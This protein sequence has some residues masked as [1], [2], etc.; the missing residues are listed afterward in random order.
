[1]EDSQENNQE[2]IVN[3]GK[4][5]SKEKE[6]P[7]KSIESLLMGDDDEEEEIEDQDNPQLQ[8]LDSLLRSGSDAINYTFTNESI[9]Y[10]N[11]DILLAKH[12]YVAKDFMFM[13]ILLMSSALNFSW[14]YFPFLF[15][16]FLCYFLI[17]KNSICA[18]KSKLFIEYIT[19]IYA[20]FLLSVKVYFIITIKKAKGDIYEDY[21]E[22]IID[23][24]IP[25]LY[26]HL[27]NYL[28]MISILGECLII[29]FSIVSIIISYLC[30]DF[31]TSD[32]ISNSLSKEKFL[33]LMT[34]CIYSAYFT[35]FG[36]AIFNRS[37]STLLYIFIMNLFLYFVSMNSNRRFIFY[38]FKFFSLIMIILLSIQILLINVFNINSIRNSYIDEDAEERPYPRIVNFWT[39]L[40]INQAF[41]FDMD[42]SK[43]TKEF[44][45]YFFAV[46]SLLIYVYSFK[47][48]TKE[49]MINAY[50]NKSEDDLDEEE[51]ELKNCFVKCIEKVIDYFLSPGFI[52]HLC[53][54]SAILWLY[55][56]QNFYSIG[57]I[58]WIFFSFL[59][60]HITLNR[61]VTIIFLSPMVIACLF[62]YHLSN[63]DG[64]FQ[65]IKEEDK[66][67]YKRFG[68]AKF[69]HKVIEY[70]L[71]NI[72]YFLV[73]SFTYTIF[74]RIEKKKL[75]EKHKIEK[76]K[77]LKL[78]V[79]KEIDISNNE[80]NIINNNEQSNLNLISDENENN[81]M[82]ENINDEKI[83]ELYKNLTLFNIILKAIFSNIDKFTL[84]AMYFLAVHSINILHFILVII[85]MF[86]LLLPKVLVKY[87]IA[88][89]IFCQIIFLAEYIIHLFK[90]NIGES[91]IELI[92]IFIPFEKDSQET[93]IEYL[94]Y[95]VAY[96]YYTQYQLNNYAFYQKL[97]SDKDLTLSN[98]VDVKLNEYPIFQKILF[99]IGK[100]ILELY[101]W[102]LISIF[103]V[104]DSTLEISFLFAIKLLIFL[105][106]V[107]RF[108]LVI[109]SDKEYPMNL[110]LNWIFLIFCSLNTIAVYTFQFLC[111]FSFFNEIIDKSDNFFIQNFPAFGLYRY[112]EE[113]LYIK[114]LP[115]F[116]SNLISVLF[117]VEM[118]RLIEED[119]EKE[120]EKKIK[121]SIEL[122]II[123]DAEGKL[124]MKK[125]T[126]ETKNKLLKKKKTI[127]ETKKNILMK[128]KTLDE[129][130]HK[131][132][133]KKKSL[134]LGDKGDDLNEKEKEKEKEDK[135]KI[136]STDSE[137]KSEEKENKL[138]IVKDSEEE[139]E[140]EKMTPAQEYEDNKSKMLILE[141][142]Y[143]FYNIILICTKFYW[144][145]LFLSICIIFTTYDLSIILIVYILIFGITFIRMFHHIINRLTKFISKESFFISRLIRFNLIE[146]VRHVSENIKYRA[147]A[148]KWLLVFSFLSYYLFYLNAIFYL[149]QK[150][151]QK[152][153]CDQ[154]HSPIFDDKDTENKIISIT[155]ILGFDVNLK[156]ENVL[157]AGWV[158]LFF[159]GLIC[160]DVYVQK[161]EN[162][163]NNISKGNRKKYRQ[164]ANRNIQLK[165][166]TFGEDNILMN[167]GANIEKAKTENEEQN[168]NDEIKKSDSKN[169]SK[170]LILKK[171]QTIKMNI[172]AKDAVED[173]AIGRKLIEDFLLIFDRA[174]QN[175]VKLSKTNS[176]YRII[177]IIKKI[178]EEIIIFL[179]ICTAI[180]KLNIWSFIYMIF[181]IYLILT[182]KSMMKYYV[183]YCFIIATIILQSI[184]FVSNLHLNT[185]PNPDEE[186]L[187]IMNEYFHIP[188]YKDNQYNN[189][190]FTNYEPVLNM[191]DEY[192]F[193]YGFGVSHSQ[194]NLI[195][196][197]FI[198]VVILYIYLDYFSYSIYQEANTIGKTSNK[199]FKINYYNLYLNP[200]VREIGLKM[201]KKEYEKHENCMKYNFDLQILNF[202][203][204]KY[205]M[206]NG[207]IKKKDE[208]NDKNKDNNL[209]K[210]EEEKKKEIEEKKIEKLPIHLEDDDEDKEDKNDENELDIN[211]AG[212][213]KTQIGRPIFKTPEPSPLQKALSKAKTLAQSQSNI[214]S[215][216]KD[217][218][219]SGN[220]CFNI[221]RQFIYLSIHNVI[222]IVII[223]ISMMISGL[224]SILYITFSLYFLITSTRIYLGNKYFYP[225]AIKV[226]LRVIIL[227]DI[228]L[229]ILYQSPYID[230]KNSEDKKNIDNNDHPNGY[231]ILEIIGLNKILFFDS[232]Y[233]AI[234]DRDQMILVLAKAIIYLCM[235]LQV[236]VYSSQSFQ[237]YYL[238][239]IITKNYKL[240]RISLMNVFRFNNKRV[241]VM[242]RSIK[243][244]EEMTKQ[245]DELE[246]TLE[247]WN[248]NIIK[249][250]NA[251]LAL[252]K[253]DTLKSVPT[254]EENKEEQNINNDNN[255]NNDDNKEEDEKESKLLKTGS[256]FLENLMKIKST[257]IKTQ[258]SQESIDNLNINNIGQNKNNLVAQTTFAPTSNLFLKNPFQ[259][260]DE[261]KHYVP[262]NEV[263]E[264]I[265]NYI[266]GGFLIRLQLKLH[267]FAV[268]Y[269]NISS[270]ER[271][272]Y[273]RD[274]I[275]GK[276]ECTSFIENLV[277]AELKP[278]DLAHFT[279]L[280]MKE[281]ES[282]FDGTRKK[283]LEKI[284]KQK[285][286]KKKLQKGVNKVSIIGKM[287][288]AKKSVKFE[289]D[290]DINRK[291]KL[292][293]EDL[294]P[295][296]RL[297]KNK[298][299]GL[300]PNAKKQKEEENKEDIIDLKAPKFKKL[301][302]FMSNKI[303]IKYLKTGYILGAIFKDCVAFCSNNFHWVCYTAMVLNHV[304]SASIISLV[305]PLSIF[306]YAILEYPRPPK[307]YWTFCFIYTVSLS[308]LK[309]IIQ[310]NFIKG[311]LGKFIEI[312]SHYKLGLKLC[313]NTFSKDFF[314]YIL[315]D[316]LVLIILLINNYLLISKGLYLR[317]E[318]EIESVYQAMERISMTKDLV[319]E[320]SKAVKRFNDSYLLKKEKKLYKEKKVKNKDTTPGDG[321]EKID[322][323]NDINEEIEIIR[324]FDKI[325]INESDFD[326][327]TKS[328]TSRSK[329]KLAFLEKIKKTKTKSK[330]D[331]DK[332]KKED[333]KKKDKEKEKEKK[334]KEKE[335]K[336]KLKEKKKEKEKYDESKRTYF[337]T[338]F[339]RTRNEKPGNE[340]Y[341]SY[342]LTMVSI[343]IFILL[344]YTTMVQ[345]KTFGA[346]SIET[347]QFSGAMVCFLLLHI[348]FLVYDRIIFISQN[349]NN[350][351]YEYILYNKVTKR[352]LTELQ[353]NQIKSDITKEYPNIKRERFII[354]PE[355]AD[356][357]KKEYNIVY[358][359]TEEFNMPL[360]QKYLLHLIIVIFGHLF[361]FFF[362]PMIGNKNLYNEIYC[363][364][365]KAE[366]NDFLK[367]KFI[368]IFYFLYVIYFVGSGLQVKYGF[369][370]MKRKSVLKAKN[371]SLYGGIYNGYKN[372]PFLY[373]IKLGIDW[374]F[375]STCLDLFQW[376]KFES[377][378]DILY[379][380]NCAMTGINTKPIGL[381]VGKVLKIFMGG[382]LSFV[383]VII[384]IVPLLLF[385]S[386][387]PMNQLNNLTNADI[388]VEIGFMHKNSLM[389]NYTIFQNPKPQSID[390]ISDEDF[391]D[392]NYTKLS[393]TNNFPRA[394]IQT[395]V[396]PEE[397]YRNWD[398]STPQINNL[399]KLIQDRNKTTDVNETQ[400]NELDI[401]EIYLSISYS[402]YRL[403]PAGAQNPKKS[404]NKT[405]FSKHYKKEDEEKMQLLNDS[406]N[407]LSL[408]L[409]NCND[410]NVTF[411]E[412]I[413]PPIRL[414]VG[415]HPK[416]FTNKVYINN[417]DVQLGF[418]GCK[419]IYEKNEN[420]G[421]ENSRISYLESYF[422]FSMINKKTNTTEGIKFHV[423]S[424]EVSSQTFS[425]SAL[426]FYVAFVLVIGNYVRNFFSGQP[427]K[428]SLTE[429]PHND[430]LL[431]LCEGIK[432]SRYS[433]NFEEE[434]KLY[435]IL[436]EIMRSPDYLRLLTNSS[437]DQFSQRLELTKPSKTTDDIE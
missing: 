294:N 210:K 121:T 336:E 58:I 284:K 338:L 153:D 106:L 115:H 193:F 272:S 205:Y 242:E 240:M 329:K 388:K 369:Y 415:S 378:Y 93:S 209:I 187:K 327:E 83:N 244:R 304:M 422:T 227:I 398:L 254:I 103:V 302:K 385:S 263:F 74:I 69:G 288:K 373:E 182:Q 95:V 36:F 136:I 394:Q 138:S 291:S 79:E 72:F 400:D 380:T 37:I 384:L 195:W 90:I 297:T 430:V 303:F 305:Y 328:K 8:S 152:Q 412:I 191:T 436:I 325:R 59:F 158:H 416:R 335:K 20:L 168:K 216:L 144:L 245:M 402:F 207:K 139:E 396:F 63:I 346:V 132:L 104:F 437:I 280:E 238:S 295:E 312:S 372:V 264:T 183:L 135:D 298:T 112:K 179:L 391:I 257:P 363:I 249:F 5:E 428:I 62:C 200:Q 353:F 35:I 203:D 321:S 146:Q 261:G 99:Y 125:T 323:E 213:Y 174:S 150:G 217:D 13:L 230:K 315:F 307:G 71:C 159:A 361:V 404:Y 427:E 82:K 50:Q 435:Y 256:S 65:D 239:Y 131:T 300:L 389:K 141:I 128:R 423:F 134:K 219:K 340:Y 16:S 375:T 374:T 314:I 401:E 56:Y 60:V 348:I 6:I 381:Q 366:C 283:K 296:K 228:S 420:D 25:Y 224:I 81:I 147:I 27:S 383:L 61:Y 154:N 414:T 9:D 376:N 220:K 350:L 48:L 1:M 113:N 78:E 426:T 225:K 100:I 356:K 157:F 221:I 55:N 393:S 180:S 12:L 24:G 49:K 324:R 293:L 126:D 411:E 96:C 129:A 54:I 169:L 331:S 387:N 133:L 105:L 271:D 32:N 339:P 120:K 122:N 123:D 26:E 166:L 143:C 365:G 175:D 424:D 31:D 171:V 320:D 149:I 34:R 322:D 76:E 433:F 151:C 259:Q 273:E 286:N 110:I 397:N 162:Y 109:Q 86:Q 351:I 18:K 119:E 137:T 431:N 371:N 189:N 421:S 255:E 343:I 214:L 407:D 142:K 367:N 352:P 19:L 269:D 204:F 287:K 276:I 70:I 410:V 107:Y 344:F 226:L 68:L 241:Q 197:D 111:L 316:S 333:E 309:F 357:L 196:M 306:C 250:N 117:I 67:I 94:I 364:E 434:E 46:S 279:R 33:R 202:D 101:I 332:D 358:I 337:Q 156:E 57:V 178:F 301:E 390:A 114:F 258:E 285:E 265:R 167:I 181:A 392:Y 3:E 84:I 281:V 359:Q 42:M 39:Q 237:E 102:S 116:M 232:S 215:N 246:K 275:Q 51:E 15:I 14:L 87:S 417:L 199:G 30:S 243:I 45:G 341:V 198:Q 251:N 89:L 124:L 4:K 330:K 262:E 247:K 377:V 429:M 334:E 29:V 268:S 282:Y 223:I 212:N 289:V 145:F 53:R 277:D 308:T 425:S 28:M 85:F 270:N 317:R 21:E 23:L 278:L 38:F 362:M 160:F 229:Q 211:I 173:N 52:Q 235:S 164:L 318:Q 77:K 44:C 418:V 118:K 406:L 22:L 236:L 161:I 41:H 47:K 11:N 91:A 368:I 311:S 10:E 165:P 73:N 292:K 379:T 218:E 326:K 274:T 409:F 2:N 155:Y 370:D 233:E 66:L 80:N 88:I 188:W 260:E 405:L 349:R 345:D 185:D 248:E 172:D 148:F 92:K 7:I 190:N 192:A 419:K 408:A 130:K 98:Y 194:I 313:N 310:L 252:S 355:Y 97:I 382:T 354:P 222:L 140:E 342:T 234:V 395:V 267:R 386:L 290:D 360:F 177:Q 170:S 432:I 108:L 413:S 75:K 43:I 206:K 176:K 319:L 253:N 231:S 201:N 64:L 40:G 208:E 347:K 186:L 127:D 184:I 403:L 299:E 399:I 17:F 266:L 163:Y